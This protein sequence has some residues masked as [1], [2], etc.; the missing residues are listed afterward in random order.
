MSKIIFINKKKGI[1][2]ER[3]YFKKAEVLKRQDVLR[4]W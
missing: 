4:E 2:V 3:E 1:P